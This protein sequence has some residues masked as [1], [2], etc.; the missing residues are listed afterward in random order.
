MNS[1]VQDVVF[2]IHGTFSH[3]DEDHFEPDEKNPGETA[4]WWQ[5]NS[6]FVA[7]MDRLLDGKACCWPED[8]CQAMPWAK[9]SFWHGV[10]EW[11]IRGW[12]P[13][14]WIRPKYRI[15]N[16]Q[17]FVWSGLNSETERRRAGGRLLEGLLS[18]ERDNEAKLKA[19]EAPRFYHLIGHSHGGSVIWN[20]LRFASHQGESLPHLKSW[21]TLGTPFPTYA[22]IKYLAVRSLVGLV[23]LGVFGWL[24][25]RGGELRY[26]GLSLPTLE[27]L[28]SPFS[29]VNL[30][31]FG[32]SLPTVGILAILLVLAGGF[33]IAIFFWLV[34]WKE[35][36]DD[37]RDSDNAWRRFG[38]RWLGL[39][40]TID[41]AIA[42]SQN[43]V[44]FY[45]TDLFR[46]PSPALPPVPR[47][48]RAMEFV[49]LLLRYPI[50][51]GSCL[52]VPLANLV[53]LPLA[54]YVSSTILRL[55]FQGSDRPGACLTLISPV[56][57]SRKSSLD[58][59]ALG[60][61]PPSLE[62]HLRDLAGSEISSKVLKGRIGFA[63]DARS[64]NSPHE[65]LR[66][67][68]SLNVSNELIHNSYYNLDAIRRV[69]AYRILGPD[70]TSRS[71]VDLGLDPDTRSWVEGLNTASP[72]RTYLPEPKPPNNTPF[73]TQALLAAMVLLLC[74]MGYAGL[75][76]DIDT[77]YIERLLNE[78]TDPKKIT[79]TKEW[80]RPDL[81]RQA[82]VAFQRRA[83][84]RLIE[85]IANRDD[86]TRLRGLAYL[87]EFATPI[88][89]V[90]INRRKASPIQLAP[91]SIDSLIQLAFEGSTNQKVR[92]ETL[93]LLFGLPDRKE[94]GNRLADRFL[95]GTLT[96]AR[97]SNKEAKIS[98]FAPIVSASL[99][100]LGAGGGEGLI[101]LYL[102]SKDYY[103][104]GRERSRLAGV[105]RR[106]EPDVL[107]EA[108]KP[109]IDRLN[110]ADA[111]VRI[112]MAD[113]LGTIG[114]AVAPHAIKPLVELFDDPDPS[115]RYAAVQALASIG[116]PSAASEKV[117]PL[118]DRLIDRDEKV[119]GMAALALELLGPAA[120]PDAVK[121]LVERLGDSDAS[122]RDAAVMA[123]GRIGPVAATEALK[124]LVGLM[125]RTDGFSQSN[126]VEALSLMGPT[127]APELVKPLITMLG[128]ISVLQRSRAA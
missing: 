64:L 111:K 53:V 104:G 23:V 29:P 128:D 82:L 37:S 100:H 94:V 88:D 12:K 34:R 93:R 51:L 120:A 48:W 32:V 5:K 28:F 31:P 57:Y 119:R 47:S 11:T 27:A 40:S 74:G 58:E 13:F 24:A 54:E 2:L 115:V 118:I 92:I 89:D 61:L 75:K 72:P 10:E 30:I 122:V 38:G 83:E 116:G 98:R 99:F 125:R 66:A 84:P 126:A 105:V 101:R 63:T 18:L 123:L 6:D 87:Q 103:E 7:E 102:V 33:L 52:T 62:E 107:S 59:A 78:I 76:A 73:S 110:D 16:R 77:V 127:A 41:E 114:T 86:E 3:R 15:L 112:S 106:L 117:K 49:S 71:D 35:N 14:R 55:K 79:E 26:S 91:K 8:I 20:A 56:P 25:L 121:P 21:S 44:G 4:A 17:L 22:P 36:R 85:R 69:L 68:F 96:V 65:L 9:R 108:V 80:K 90:S 42:G 67:Y 113:A 95:H 45:V 19:G 50:W 43:T 124:P 1:R 60:P 39:F 81:L 46:L 109:L 70:R 97:N